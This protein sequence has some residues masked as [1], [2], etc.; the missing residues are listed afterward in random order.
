MSTDT[1]GGRGV[2]VRARSGSSG[3][4]ASVA[5]QKGQRGAALGT[6]FRQRQQDTR[7]EAGCSSAESDRVS[8]FGSF[9]VAEPVRP[10]SATERGR[11]RSAL[12]ALV[13]EGGLH[14][15]EEPHDDDD[16]DD[17]TRQ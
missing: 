5:E 1:S 14:R 10:E 17:H 7:R 6:I 3:A 15:F 11:F 8:G 16:L 13:S 12:L 4:A 9:I 2:A